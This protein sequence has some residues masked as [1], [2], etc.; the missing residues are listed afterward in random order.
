M[1]SVAHEFDSGNI[2]TDGAPL[3][4]F[5]NLAKRGLLLG[6]GAGIFFLS[7]PLLLL[8]SLGSC[9]IVSAGMFCVRPLHR[10]SRLVLINCL[11]WLVTGFL[12]GGLELGALRSAAF[13]RGG[14]RCFLF[15]L[16]FRPFRMAWKWLLRPVLCR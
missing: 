10:T 2:R 14:G 8:A 9:L 11:F 15:Y 12:S 6:L 1:T 3:V 4:I 5:T 7:K 13:W 16:L